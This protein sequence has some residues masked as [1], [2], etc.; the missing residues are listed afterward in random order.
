MKSGGVA[1][2]GKGGCLPQVQPLGDVGRSACNVDCCVVGLL[3]PR[4]YMAGH[5][6]PVFLYIHYSALENHIR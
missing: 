6:Q 3:G 5:E 1:W 4:R 2:Q